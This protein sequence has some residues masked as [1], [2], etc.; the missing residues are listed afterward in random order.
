MIPQT[1]DLQRRKNSFQSVVKKE[2]AK[3]A[4]MLEGG[5]HS[6]LTTI[7]GGHFILEL[8]HCTLQRA[9]SSVQQVSANHPKLTG[10]V[11]SSLANIISLLLDAQQP[12]AL[13]VKPPQHK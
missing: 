2:F 1:E 13:L 3:S 5:L 9:K 8:G 4:G 6:A 11:V 10:L 7:P 12:S